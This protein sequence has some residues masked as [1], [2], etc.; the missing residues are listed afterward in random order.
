MVPVSVN[1]LLV[2]ALY[3]ERIDNK[4]DGAIAGIHDKLGKLAEVGQHQLQ[5]QKKAHKLMATQCALGFV[6]RMM[7]MMKPTQQQLHSETRH[8]HRLCLICR[9]LLWM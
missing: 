7:M 8:R 3:Q 9:R 5:E 4:R 6:F 2:A 1:I